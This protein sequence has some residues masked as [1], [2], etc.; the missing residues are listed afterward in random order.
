MDV[1]GVPH[2]ALAREER[3]AI[4][5]TLHDERRLERRTDHELVDRRKRVGRR[6]TGQSQH[7]TLRERTPD[8]H[9]VQRPPGRSIS[10]HGR[11]IVRVPRHD[12]GRHAI[13][14]PVI[15]LLLRWPN[16]REHAVTMFAEVA[17]LDRTDDMAVA[18]DE[19]MAVGVGDLERSVRGSV[20]HLGHWHAIG[21]PLVVG[22]IDA[23]PPTLA[24]TDRWPSP[25]AR[26]PAVFT[27]SQR[28][29][30]PLHTTP[31][32][33]VRAERVS[34]NDARSMTLMGLSAGRGAG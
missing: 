19:H 21:M 29:E 5:R 20:D 17:P 7:A 26:C 18:Y 16:L 33:E 22:G 25:R 14:K 10:G 2:T 30:P 13:G 8:L 6:A 9:V 24:Q 28:L 11:C 15:S 4:A 34:Q 23:A 31:R 3:V 32:L 1:L 27:D 12:T